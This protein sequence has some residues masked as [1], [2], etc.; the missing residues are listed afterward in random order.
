MFDVLEL[1][2]REKIMSIILSFTYKKY[3]EILIK[4]LVYP[5]GLSIYL[6]ILDSEQYNFN[7]KQTVELFCEMN[8]GP[9]SETV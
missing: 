4:L 1:G 9:Q 8:Y 7:T 2:K 5:F 6:Q 3:P